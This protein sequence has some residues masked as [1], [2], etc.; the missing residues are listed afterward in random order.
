MYALFILVILQLLYSR[1]LLYIYHFWNEE[2]KI[3]LVKCANVSNARAIVSKMLATILSMETNLEFDHI[4]NSYTDIQD[5]S[6][7]NSRCILLN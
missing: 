6:F 4:G 7:T 3:F 2:N 1:T 5:S